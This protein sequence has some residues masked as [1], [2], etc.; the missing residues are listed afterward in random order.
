[1]ARHKRHAQP[2][3]G[4]ADIRHDALRQADIG[5]FAIHQQQLRARGDSCRNEIGA[6]V[7]RARNRGEQTSGTDVAAAVG[8]FTSDGIGIA[9]EDRFRKQRTQ[10]DRLRWGARRRA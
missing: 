2:D 3:I 4:R 5:D 7:L 9:A 1:M 8:D 10:P 6:V